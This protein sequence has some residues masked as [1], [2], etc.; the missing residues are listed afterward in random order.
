MKTILKTYRFALLP[1]KEQEALLDI[2]FG[3]VRFVFSKNILAEGLRII[4]AG[5]SDYTDGGSDQTS[6]KKH[7]PVKSEAH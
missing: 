4:G 5:L 3:C 2:H 1:T 6:E 7:K